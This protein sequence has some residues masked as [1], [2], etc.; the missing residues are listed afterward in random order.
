MAFKLKQAIPHLPHCEDHESTN[1]ANYHKY[2]NRLFMCLK[3]DL[4]KP[5]YKLKINTKGI[6]FQTFKV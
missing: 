3:F 4:Y 2:S 6:H 5:N 1:L